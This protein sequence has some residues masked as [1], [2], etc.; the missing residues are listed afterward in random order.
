MKS[1]DGN[2]CL[3]GCGRKGYYKFGFCVTCKPTVKCGRCGHQFKPHRE[4][5]LCSECRN[6]KKARQAH[7]SSAFS[8]Y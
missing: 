2:R 4:Q 7:A 8:E 6:A 3:G 1:N 5:K